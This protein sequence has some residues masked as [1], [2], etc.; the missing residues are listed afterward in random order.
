MSQQK[1]NL[2]NNPLKFISDCLSICMLL[3]AVYSTRQYKEIFYTMLIMLFIRS[4][5]IICTILPSQKNCDKTSITYGCYDKLYSGHFATGLVATL[6]CWKYNTITSIVFYS[7]NFINATLIML[8]RAH[9]TND[10]LMALF[11][12]LSIHGILIPTILK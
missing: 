11:A 12:T 7:L 3:Y 2:N 8:L 9:Y 4:I 10:I 6:V 1:L 5:C